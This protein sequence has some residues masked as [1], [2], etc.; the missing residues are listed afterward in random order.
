MNVEFKS[1]PEMY[2]KEHNGLKRNTVIKRDSPKD[3]RFKI[4]RCFMKGQIHNLNITIVNTDTSESFT[5]EV[6]DVTQWGDLYIIS[7]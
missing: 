5:R 3:F 4:L 1:I 7:W 2:R 6:T